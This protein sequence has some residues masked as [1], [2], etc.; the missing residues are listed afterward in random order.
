MLDVIGFGALNLDFIYEVDSL[1]R[2]A[3]G[4]PELRPGRELDTDAGS[5]LRIQEKVDR[6]GRF[7]VQAPGGSAA[8]TISALSRMGF[9]TGFIGK[10]GIDPEGQA[11]LAEM[12]GTDLRGVVRGD[13]SGRCL[14]ILDADRDRFMMLQPNANDN[15][16][17][18][19]VNHGFAGAARYVHLTSF[20]GEAPFAA[21]KALV[22]Q[23]SPAV[24]M[25]FD[26]GEI[27][28][29]RG[30]DASRPIIQRCQVIFSTEKE[31]EALTGEGC[32]SGSQRLLG[33]GPSIIAC[34]RGERGVSLFTHTDRIDLPPEPVEVVDNTGAGDVF[35]A[36]FLAGLLLNRP[37]IECGRFGIRIASR[38]LRGFGRSHYPNKEDLAFFR[39]SP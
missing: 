8:N 16:S 6:L 30:L 2:I 5:F 15:L 20:V 21:Q 4:E 36:G 13:R 32:V 28:A 7:R 35:N 12:K 11:L 27:Y 39:I 26:P 3:A 23:M 37:L 24:Q 22:A 31:I 14:C 38:S 1:D 19:E 25:T 34:K 29:R 33:M 10:V 9:R 18:E 17:E